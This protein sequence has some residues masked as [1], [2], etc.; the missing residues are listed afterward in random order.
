MSTF[1]GDIELD[2]VTSFQ[3]SRPVTLTS[4]PVEQG[5]D[6][7]DHI[8]EEPF[9]I[10]IESTYS[11]SSPRL[12]KNQSSIIRQR[13]IL[14]TGKE[15]EIKHDTRTY[16]NMAMQDISFK[17]SSEVGNSIQFT[18]TFKHIVKVAIKTT[19]R[20]VTRKA[21]SKKKAKAG[22]QVPKEATE[23]QK[24]KSILAKLDDTTGQAM[25]KFLTGK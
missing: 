24:K 6:I 20:V 15:I 19:K 2:V 25:S 3:E 11:D 21:S 17:D 16:S 12:K 23:P 8:R 7:T 22:S 18:A 14:L 1:I 5:A 10:T 9:T 4:H 13:L